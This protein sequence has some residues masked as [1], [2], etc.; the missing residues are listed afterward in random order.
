MFRFDLSLKFLF[1]IL[2]AFIGFT[3]IGTLTHELGHV[4]VAEFLGY[5]TSLHYDSMNYNA[6]S[7]DEDLI[8]NDKDFIKLEHLYEEH[9]KEIDNGVFEEDIKFKEE[10]ERL[11]KILKEKYP[12]IKR[13]NVYSFYITMGGPIQTILTSLIGL[14]ILFFRKF[15]HKNTFEILDWLG[16][17]LSLFI[18]REVYN[19]IMALFSLIFFNTNRF[20]GDE[21]GI[22]LYLELN[23]WI[24]PVIT[25]VVGV[26]VSLYVIFKVMPYKYRIG[27]MSSGLI[28]GILGY[29]LWFEFL[30][31]ILLP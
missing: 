17:F 16:V 3:I 12:S 30:G 24:V 31:E 11:D 4:A 28:G 2:I 5:E 29:V 8:K 20:N 9:Y 14:F 18:L 21:F 10:V 25:G 22:S 7:I 13:Q 23:Q 6:S 27:F 15:K 1:S 19:T 26:L